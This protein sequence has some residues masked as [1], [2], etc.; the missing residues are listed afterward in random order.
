M[1]LY[2]MGMFHVEQWKVEFQKK[3]QI[4]SR[5]LNEGRNLILLA[6]S[7]DFVDCVYVEMKWNPES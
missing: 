1:K 4:M 2:E 5:K 6:D 3:D 7:I